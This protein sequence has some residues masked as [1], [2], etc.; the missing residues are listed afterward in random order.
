MEWKQWADWMEV[1]DGVVFFGGIPQF[2]WEGI[3]DFA[4]AAL[5]GLIIA[6]ATT[7]YFKK[8]DESTRVAGVILEKRVNAQ[9]A[10]VDFLERENYKYELPRERSQKL[11][12]RLS[13]LGFRLPYGPSLQYSIVFG[14]LERFNDYFEKLQALLAQNRL[15]IDKK[16]RRHLMLLQG[17]YAQINSLQLVVPSI[18]LPE[19][20]S[21]LS[22]EEQRTAAGEVL[23]QL[24]ILLDEEINGLQR[25]LDALVVDS[26][27]KLDLKRPKKSLMRNNMMNREMASIALE[28]QNE[29]VLGLE[30]HRIFCM[31]ER[32]VYEFRGLP[33]TELACP[34]RSEPP[35]GR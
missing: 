4:A 9:Q 14:S 29:T 2:L 24:G 13:E 18:P 35:V 34:E 19:G 27:Y 3:L 21:P 28:L 12:E 8:K 5:A 6:V 23:L 10:I 20:E 17:Y 33:P 25:E 1:I 15:W 31:V 16:V 26:I 11:Y 32:T 7:F 30:K 22:P